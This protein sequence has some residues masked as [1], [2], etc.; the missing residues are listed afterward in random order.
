[1]KFYTFIQIV[2]MCIYV[3]CVCMFVNVISV[4]CLRLVEDDLERIRKA[5]TSVQQQNATP[6]EIQRRLESIRKQKE[7]K[8]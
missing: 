5:E 6:R 7:T 3:F 4:M 8:V 1:M 2:Y